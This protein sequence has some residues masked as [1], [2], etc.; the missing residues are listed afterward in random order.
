MAMADRYTPV[1]NYFKLTGEISER[2][3]KEKDYSET[4]SEREKLKPKV[5]KVLAEDTHEAIFDLLQSDVETDFSL[6]KMPCWLIVSRRDKLE[7]VQWKYAGYMTE[8]KQKVME[9]KFEDKGYAAE[10]WEVDGLSSTPIS[11]DEDMLYSEVLLSLGHEAAHKYFERKPLGKKY[12][13]SQECSTINETSADIIG[14][15]V[16]AYQL[17][18]MPKERADL[19]KAAI[20]EM[21]SE[22]AADEDWGK[23][24]KT[25]EGLLSKGEIE[26]AE[27]YMERERE[28]LNKEYGTHIR[29]INQATL[30][31]YKTYGVDG[32]D[33]NGITQHLKDLRSEC[34]DIKDYA[35][36]VGQTTSYKEVERALKRKRGGN[37]YHAFKASGGYGRDYSGDAPNSKTKSSYA[38][39]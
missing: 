25:V 8:D 24:V 4:Y 16:R 34:S 32:G 22:K 21:Q 9:K 29:K 30:V 1:R 3:E 17:S 2:R 28:K 33:K 27:T 15:E 11:L 23:I 38:K 37:G 31:K 13:T 18:K 10:V 7:A 35:E 26:K 39:K 12:D 14:D 36:T 5:E 19:K 20:R 6:K